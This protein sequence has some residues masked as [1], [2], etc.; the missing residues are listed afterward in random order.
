MEYIKGGRVGP[1]V[2]SLSWPAA[3]NHSRHE[4]Q[5]CTRPTC[6]CQS[7]RRR[8]FFS[9][10]VTVVDQ[11]KVE[12]VRCALTAGPAEILHHANRQCVSRLLGARDSGETERCS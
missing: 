3:K 2:R 7:G 10:H 12:W 8:A 5:K 6:G 11:I 9:M 4:V 1:L